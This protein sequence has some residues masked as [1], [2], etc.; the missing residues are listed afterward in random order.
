MLATGPSATLLV[1]L[2]T[3]GAD[4]LL[5]DCPETFIAQPSFSFLPNLKPVETACV[6]NQELDRRNKT[7]R[8]VYATK[9]TGF[10]NM[11]VYQVH[12]MKFFP[13]FFKE[14]KNCGSLPEVSL[15]KVKKLEKLMKTN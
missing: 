4:L 12:E 5:L 14:V 3:L 13:D 15:E 10:Y 1:N 7:I 9:R 2:K 8:C 11:T 6:P